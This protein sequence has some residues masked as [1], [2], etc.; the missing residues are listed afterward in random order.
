MICSSVQSPSS[1]C[2]ALLGLIP[3]AFTSGAV[4][5]LLEIVVRASESRTGS[6]MIR[7]VYRRALRGSS[8]RHFMSYGPVVCIFLNLLLVSCSTA[9]VLTDRRLVDYRTPAYQN[10]FE[11]DWKAQCGG[12]E[13][14]ISGPAE[15]SRRVWR[16]TLDIQRRE[17]HLG[18][19]L[20][21]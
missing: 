4:R 7:I 9:L 17:L 20:D 3:I 12:D 2:E 19:K 16:A 13:R 1:G 6:D 11:S 14:L 15:P 5:Q 10:R 21:N 8:Q 18:Q